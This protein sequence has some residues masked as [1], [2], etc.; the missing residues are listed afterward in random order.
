MFADIMGYTAMMQENEVH[1]LRSQ[2]KFSKAIDREVMAH[3]GRII[4]FSGDGVLCT[5][6][7]AIDAVQS[8]IAIQKEM[9][10]D[11]E[12]PLRIGIHSGDVMVDEKNIYGDGVN[13]ASRIESFA[14][15]GGIFISAKVY[16]E[17]KNQNNIEA[18]SLG[19]F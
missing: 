12:V 7:S 11:P 2:E 6:N 10:S 3:N 15:A 9:R 18:I 5:F 17:I 19:T 16:D 14:V 8:A 1:A 13:I 4:Q